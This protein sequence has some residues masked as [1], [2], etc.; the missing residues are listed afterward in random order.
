MDKQISGAPIIDQNAKV[1]SV[2]SQSDLLQFIALDGMTKTVNTYLPK[3]PQIEDLVS[4]RK[5]DLFRDVFRQFL[6]KPVGR[7]IVTDGNGGLQGL[8]SKSNLLKAFKE[9]EA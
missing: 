2:I 1:I 3:L 8:V 5:T 9:A 7:I 6:V 4:V